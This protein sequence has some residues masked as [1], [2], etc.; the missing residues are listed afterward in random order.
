MLLAGWLAG[1]L[2]G[3]LAGWLPGWLAG[4]LPGWLA[5]SFSSKIWVSE[6][7]TRLCWAWKAVWPGLARVWRPSFS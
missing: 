5:A 2:V 4:W 6:D 7:R 3:W 1:W